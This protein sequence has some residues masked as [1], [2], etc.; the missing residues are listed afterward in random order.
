MN[1]ELTTI[2]LGI[3]P[4]GTDDL[5]LISLLQACKLLRGRKGRMALQTVQRFAN[6]SRG[7]IFGTVRVV[8]PTVLRSGVR[9]TTLAAIQAWQKKCD[10][11][12]NERPAPNR[13]GTA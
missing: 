11:L 6:P 5:E 9:L 1:P 4:A 10:Q 8:L 3:D 12:G 7:R 13:K 2:D